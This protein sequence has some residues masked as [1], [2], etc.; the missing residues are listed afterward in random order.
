MNIDPR[1]VDAHVGRRIREAR[2][3]RGLHT[4]IVGKAAGVSYQQV[5]KYENGSNRVSASV[6]YIIAAAL[7]CRIEYFFE[8]L[9]DTAKPDTRSTGTR[10]SPTRR[11]I[12][13]LAIAPDGTTIRFPYGTFASPNAAL[14]LVNKIGRPGWAEV[15]TTATGTSIKK[16]GTP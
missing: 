9:P 2:E 16:V 8:G 14:I 10:K 6:L 13:E 7:E 1:M 11:R 5:Q 12:E 3:E 4:S 15:K